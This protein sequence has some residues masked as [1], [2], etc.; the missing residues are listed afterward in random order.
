M[1]VLIFLTALACAPFVAATPGGHDAVC[2]TCDGGC[3]CCG[4]CETGSCRCTQCGCDCCVDECP[5]TGRAAGREACG[6]GCC[7]R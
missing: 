2:A 4:C 6:S 3:D 1:N 5:T 7:S